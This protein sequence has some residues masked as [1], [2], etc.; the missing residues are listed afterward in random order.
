[1]IR[2]AP[3]SLLGVALLTAAPLDAAQPGDPKPQVRTDAIGDPLPPHARA[4][5]GTTRGG[6]SSKMTGLA[7]SPDGKLLASGDRERLDIRDA[8]TGRLVRV[9]PGDFD[10][11]KL[12]LAFAA[13]G[14]ALAAQTANRQ[15]VA[16][17]EAATG[18]LLV[19]LATQATLSCPPAFAPD[20]KLVATA[21]EGKGVSIWNR[22][23][24]KVVAVLP[25]QE[26]GVTSL[27]FSA[28]GNRLAVVFRSGTLHVWDVRGEP[29]VAAA[30]AAP[31]EKPVSAAVS[32]RL[33][34]LA[35]AGE[36]EVRLIDVATGKQRL[37]LAYTGRGALA[38]VW[39]AADGKTL[40]GLDPRQSLLAVWDTAS[41][42][43][44]HLLNQPYAVAPLI[45]WPDGRTVTGFDGTQLRRWDVFSGRETSLT[46]GPSQ[47]LKSVAVAPDGRT[48]AVSAGIGQVMVWDTATGA[49]GPVLQA[50]GDQ[51][52][53]IAFA[54]DGTV[55]AT[56]GGSL[57]L[58]DLKTGKVLRTLETEGGTSNFV[59]FAPDGKTVASSLGLPDGRVRLWRVADGGVSRDLGTGE[60][61]SWGV[62]YSPDG[63][64]LAVVTVT[65]GAGE[66][67]AASQVDLLDVA[68][69]RKQRFK[70]VRANRKQ[71]AFSPDGRLLAVIHLPAAGGAEGRVYEVLSGELLW[72]AAV[73]FG[74]AT[75]LAFTADSRFLVT[76]HNDGGVRW[77]DGLTGEP[78]QHWTGHR[79]S[80]A[81]LALS[82]DGRTLVTASADG[83]ALVWDVPTHRNPA[84]LP[85]AE[86]ELRACWALLADADGARAWDGV[87]RMLAAGDGSVAWM[88]PLLRLPPPNP[89]VA[90]W[91]ADLESPRFAVRER[92]STELVKLQ[93]RAV[94]ALLTRLEKPLSLEAQRRIEQ[95][96]A[97]VR[98]T[99]MSAEQRQVMRAVAVLEYHRSPAARQLLQELAGGA[100]GERL[101]REARA[102][103][104]RLPPS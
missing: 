56:G 52:D 82:A 83:T 51:A 37:A 71:V 48:A 65:L 46:A 25:H 60:R 47:P 73:H 104:G 41:G 92:A 40:F 26:A 86:R 68:S 64:T 6:D 74:T 34:L 88:R 94:P 70:D 27:A 22:A 67:I 98:A 81:S 54:P 103:L 102:A 10:P 3:S 15:E 21:V 79:Q 61:F 23:G 33:D 19:K 72:S 28:D 59:A 17:F 12:F 75:C 2:L 32:P 100:T 63:T 55:I 1:M 13:D 77:W 101:T 80:T 58:W 18:K 78:K 20:G 44:T 45:P 62:R 90:R 97:K 43:R 29:R 85:L 89:D 7:I 4:R 16:V 9:V 14:K 39:F 69:G 36:M 53:A 87:R 57:R 84:A 8:A 11:N 38:Q 50:A 91:L 42:N 96:L 5:F 49:P 31:L 66:S 30:I 99:P 93:E 24:G 95:I 76:G 35:V